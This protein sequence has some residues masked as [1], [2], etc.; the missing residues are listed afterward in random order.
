MPTDPDTDW[1]YGNRTA[2]IVKLGTDGKDSKLVSQLNESRDFFVRKRLGIQWYSLER[3]LFDGLNHR[4]IHGIPRESRGRLGSL[5]SLFVELREGIRRI[6]HKTPD[7]ILLWATDE[8][9]SH[10]TLKRINDTLDAYE[11]WYKSKYLVS[12]KSPPGTLASPH[13]LGKEPW[14]SP[15]QA[16]GAFLLRLFVPYHPDVAQALT[17][18]GGRCRECAAGPSCDVFEQF[19]NECLIGLEEHEHGTDQVCGDTCYVLHL[20]DADKRNPL[21][22]L[23]NR[24]YRLSAD[25]GKSAQEQ[26]WQPWRHAI[27]A[28]DNKDMRNEVRQLCSAYRALVRQMGLLPAPQQHQQQSAARAL[29]HRA[30]SIGTVGGL[31]GMQ[32]GRDGQASYGR[33]FPQQR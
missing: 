31:A 32:G 11:Y 2:L 29:G 5:V 22:G 33:F 17:D 10:T 18:A 23:I 28:L 25:I 20:S 30:R 15:W 21:G 26:P 3:Y 13:W 16:R 19:L 8:L 12:I 7:V 6:N 24:M 14:R 9:R 1:L 4:E 27:A